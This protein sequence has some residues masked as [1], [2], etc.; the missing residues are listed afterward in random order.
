VVDVPLATLD[1]ARAGDRDAL[2]SL[3]RE[4]NPG[5]V[6]YLR[7]RGLGPD[8]DD[9]AGQVWLEV[10]SGL[11]R[12]EGDGRDFARWLFTIARRRAIDEQRRRARRPEVLTADP[13]PA[14][15]AVLDAPGELTWAIALVRRLPSDQA[16]VVLLRVVAGLDVAAVADLLHRRTGTVRV[17]AHR[18]L[19]RLA[20]LAEEAVLPL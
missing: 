20:E 8:A 14:D 4:H 7:G 16:D 9:V 18:G 2:G 5:V 1:R 10:A 17:L 13:R 3:W 11:H 15:E 12:F 19:R 6:R